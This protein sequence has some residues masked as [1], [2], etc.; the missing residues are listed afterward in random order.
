MEQNIAQR[1]LNLVHR[2]DNNIC[3]AHGCHGG[4]RMLSFDS[5]GKIF[6][7]E[8]SDFPDYCIGSV[9]DH[10]LRGMVEK[11]IESGHEYFRPKDQSECKDCPWR[12][13]C[14]GGCRSAAKFACGD[15]SR[16]DT[17]ECAFNKALYPRLVAILLQDRGFAEYLQSGDVE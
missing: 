4:Y 17:T 16:L 7:C 12:Y 2:P 9:K 15:P 5:L 10:D 1:L 13:F 11:A 14:R 3:N 6:P 8:L